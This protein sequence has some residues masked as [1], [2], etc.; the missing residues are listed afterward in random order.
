[1]PL[2]FFVFERLASLPIQIQKRPADISIGLSVIF[3]FEIFINL[4]DHRKGSIGKSEAISPYFKL[5]SSVT[6]RWAKPKEP[7]FE[8]PYHKFVGYWRS[9]ACEKLD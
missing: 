8:N 3:L 2:R 7:K 9:Q 4:E 5:D 6:G 1:M